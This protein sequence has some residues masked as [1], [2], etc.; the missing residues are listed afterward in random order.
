[1]AS[2]VTSNDT[3][4]NANPFIEQTD[5]TDVVVRVG[6]VS[7]Y[8][9][10]KILSIF[11][12]VLREILQSKKEITIEDRKADHVVLFFKFFYPEQKVWITNGKIFFVIA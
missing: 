5:E 7:L 1:M 12:P 9:H 3:T 8:L 6:D 10:S 11:S 4:N 2:V